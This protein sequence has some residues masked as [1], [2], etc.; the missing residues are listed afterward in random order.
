[1]SEET[2]IEF[3]SRLNE[4]LREM[5]SKGLTNEG[6]IAVLIMMKDDIS[7]KARNDWRGPSP[8]S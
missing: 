1:M 3:A 4:L 7:D 2:T 8:L 6:A 5:A